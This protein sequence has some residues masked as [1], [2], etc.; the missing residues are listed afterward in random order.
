VSGNAN[1]SPHVSRE[2]N[3]ALARKRPILPIRIEDVAPGGALEYLLSLVQRVDAFP[4]PIQQHGTLILKRLAS[5]LRSSDT[6][7]VATDAAETKPAAK[8]QGATRPRA[9]ARRAPTA[10]GPGTVIDDFTLE[11]L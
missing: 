1:A 11:T 4:P 9:A 3:L 7:A 2:V 8:P 10:I 6:E 5:V